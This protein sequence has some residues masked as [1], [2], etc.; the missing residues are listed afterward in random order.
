MRVSWK[1]LR[2]KNFGSVRRV[3]AH[4]LQEPLIVFVVTPR[5]FSAT[6]SMIPTEIAFIP[7]NASWQTVT[8]ENSTDGMFFVGRLSL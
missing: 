4:S 7:M 5:M 8:I 2:E 3:Q 1:Q 6:L